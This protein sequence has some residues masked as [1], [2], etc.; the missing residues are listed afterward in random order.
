[1]LVVPGQVLT[2]DSGFLR[3]HGTYIEYYTNSV[4]D[5][6]GDELGDEP[7]DNTAVVEDMGMIVDDAVLDDDDGGDGGSAGCRSSA[8]ARHG[9]DPAFT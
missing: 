3:G 4:G 9:P 5:E 8:A 2:T 1:M 6:L 7:S